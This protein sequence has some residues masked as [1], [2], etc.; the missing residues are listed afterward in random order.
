M[1]VCTVFIIIKVYY[2]ICIVQ[3]SYILCIMS[4]ALSNILN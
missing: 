2:W 3:C 1:P 4:Y